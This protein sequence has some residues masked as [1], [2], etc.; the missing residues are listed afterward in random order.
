[1]C[2]RRFTWP[3]NSW[4]ALQQNIFQL[5]F[6]SLQFKILFLAILFNK[7]A[8]VSVKTSHALLLQF[9]VLLTDFFFQGITEWFRYEETSGGHLI[10]TISLSRSNF[11][12]GCSGP[13]TVKFWLSSRMEIFMSLVKCCL[14]SV[15]QDLGLMYFSLNTNTQHSDGDQS[16]DFCDETWIFWV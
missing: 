1:M 12:S 15:V 13:C 2:L 16:W 10:P 3:S 5:L 11:R 8:V 14:I 9:F 7:S 4:V 6:L